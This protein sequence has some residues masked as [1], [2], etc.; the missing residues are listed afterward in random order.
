MKV[1]L[2]YI[3]FLNQHYDCCGDVTRIGVDELTRKI[4]A[5][6]GAIEE[7]EKLGDK[8]K[9][10]IVA[11]IV[12]VVDHP[13]ADR[14][15]VVMI[16]DNG[17]VKDTERD[18]DGYIQIVC[19]AQN[20]HEGMLVAWLPPG[21][22]VPE[23]VGNEPF[24]L[25]ARELRGVKS[26]GML[27]SA[28]EL[29]LGT[30]HTGIL[31]IN[32]PFD[33]VHVGDDFASAFRL[34]DDV[35]L[36]IE[37]KMFT[38]RPDCF[39]F[40]GVSREFAG[41][42]GMQFKS[43]GWY[44]LDAVI[45][46]LEA[47]ELPFEASNELPE[48]VPRFMAIVMRDV[49][50][51]L[52]PT[53]VRVELAKIGI[54]SV[55]NIVD[56]TNLFMCE[57]AQPLHAY[58]YDKVKALSGGNKAM[59]TVRHP[60][61]GEK[62]KLLNGKEIEPRAEAIMIA[63]DKQLI[64]VG[65]V[66]GGADT[67]VDETTKHIILECGTFDMYSVRRTSM[68]HGLFTDAVTRFN[69]G[70][71]PLQN[72][73]VLAKVIDEIR[74][75]AG[76]RIASNVVDLNQVSG[77]EWVHPPVPVSVEFI[78]ERLGLTL[79]ADE[80]KQLLENVE[81]SVSV[82]GDSLTVTAPF[83]R[84]DVELRE[85]VVE[86][87][88]R[89]YGFDH[90]PLELPTRMIE[91]AHKDALLE[92]KSTIREHL[93][94]SGANEVLTYSFVHGNLLD[95]VCQDKNHAFQI[96]NAISPD[97]QYYRLSLTPSLLEKVHANI[98]SGYG[99]FALFEMGRVHYKGEM[100]A[101]D[102]EVPNEDDHLALVISTADK[103]IKKEAGAAYYEA[104]KYAMQLLPEVDKYMV[105]LKDFDFKDDDWGRQLCAMYEPNRSAV[106]V[107]NDL[108]WGI[109]GEFRATVV[110]ALKLPTHS[111]GFEIGLEVIRNAPHRAYQPLPRFPKVE[112][113]I[114]LKVSADMQYRTVHDLVIQK[115]NELQPEQVLVSLSPVDIYQ[116]SDDQS[117]KQV[118]LRLSIANYERTLTDEEVSKLLDKV[119]IAAKDAIGAERV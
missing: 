76:G 102:P 112:Q 15:H 35:I 106:I 110:K 81:F 63:T 43:P 66:M 62:I 117:H 4:G 74:S 3:R 54:R 16:D 32:D 30:D 82:D 21:I 49:R 53:W 17:A 96:S 104:K 103:D 91:P 12:S 98:K 75:C 92:L 61:P 26:N 31:E 28:R 27:A 5:Q 119:A 60:R 100:D 6:L 89:L 70:Q 56:Y 40:I 8:Y 37:N 88:G 58:D 90:L 97:L 23:T 83:W 72:R 42:Q 69:K 99:Q 55:N 57:T 85:D 79:S 47:D 86:E 64:G 115:V 80:M 10:I 114:C 20:L 94:R 65:G 41:I 107:W 24:V 59:L 36:D 78:N 50:V 11:K 38:H 39:G 1:S 93:V 9:G 77:R 52:S 44:S 7:A 108:T 46:S 13:D 22:T 45:P 18:S 105:A 25:E 87:V 84:T 19:G 33:V 116:R 68:A 118:T 109:V 71:S 2:N 113:D 111:A 34:K 101:A 73:A 95:K 29:D 48:L 67:E 14:L 51:D